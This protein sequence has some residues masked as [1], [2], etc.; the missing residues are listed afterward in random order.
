EAVMSGTIRDS[1][2]I[3]LVGLR[4]L[5]TVKDNGDNTKIPDQITWGVYKFEPRTWTP[6]DAEWKEDPGVGLRWWATDAERKGDVGYAMPRDEK[7]ADTQTY[8]LSSYI[9]ADATRTSGD[10]VVTP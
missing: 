6:S 10:I 3:E 5:L 9:Y 7:P 1:S 4:V 2:V 8:P